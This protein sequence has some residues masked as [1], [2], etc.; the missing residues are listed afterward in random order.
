MNVMY[1]G[2]SAQAVTDMVMGVSGVIS[3][4]FL[5]SILFFG[6]YGLYGVLRLKREQYLVPHRLMYP[7]YCGNE[8]CLDPVEYMDYI[9]PRLSALS[10]VFLLSGVLLLLTFFVDG[11]RTL[12]VLLTLYIAPF[13]AYLWYSGC[14][15][16]AARTYWQTG[17]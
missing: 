5:V 16:R 15:K 6:G 12:G 2:L 7:N 9:L 1:S 11:L 4:L 3:I 14:L 17:K 10:G 13:A 8:E